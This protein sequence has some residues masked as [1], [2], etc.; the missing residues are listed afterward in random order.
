MGLRKVRF[1][2][3]LIVCSTA[4]K[5]LAGC[6]GVEQT[7][8]IDAIVEIHNLE[9]ESHK[10]LLSGDLDNSDAAL[11]SALD[12]VNSLSSL[13]SFYANGL[14]IDQARIIASKGWVSLLKSEFSQ[15]REYYE[16]AFSALTSGQAQHR[17]YLHNAQLEHQ[18][19]MVF[20]GAVGQFNAQIAT[21]PTGHA[22]GTAMRRMANL[23]LG[24]LD[25][26]VEDIEFTFEDLRTSSDGIRITV[27]PTAPPLSLIGRLEDKGGGFCSAALAG[28]RTVLTNAHCISSESSS[29]E[30]GL[31][32]FKNRDSMRV[33]FE[34]LNVHDT[35]QVVAVET[36]G[37]NL[38]QGGWKKG[39][40][41]NDWAI[42]TLARHPLNRTHL[43]TVEETTLLG[44]GAELAMAGFSSDQSDGRYLSIH[45]KCRIKDINGGYYQD[46]CR[47][48]GGSSGAPVFLIT[49]NFSDIQIIG[50][51]AF[52]SNSGPAG[53]GGGPLLVGEFRK[54]LEKVLSENDGI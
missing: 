20:A 46:T 32:L 42:L 21:S 45:W 19:L 16:L 52:R 35:V 24:Q 33:H 18:N 3:F 28:P 39:D 43:K 10:Y 54:A 13:N 47:S 25:Y 50:L 1:F 51:H 5:F 44:S 26:D 30:T 12:T 23:I 15:A 17:S 36:S 11:D 22:L 34:G 2:I 6:K 4:P 53:G 41:S 7:T 14:Y 48:A 49:D 31:W 29:S 9:A 27:L 8:A 40:W 37:R 38:A